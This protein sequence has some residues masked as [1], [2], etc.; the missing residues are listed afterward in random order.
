MLGGVQS[1]SCARFLDDEEIAEFLSLISRYKDF[2][3]VSS[4]TVN[5]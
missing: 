5:D 3:I 1:F 4:F 2:I